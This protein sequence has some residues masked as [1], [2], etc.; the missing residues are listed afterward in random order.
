MASALHSSLASVAPVYSPRHIGLLLLAR[1]APA[2]NLDL[3]CAPPGPHSSS[4]GTGTGRTNVRTKGESHY[5][6]ALPSWL[7]GE[8]DIYKCL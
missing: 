3:W 6:R 8:E 7:I 1:Q 4:E 2:G 5:P